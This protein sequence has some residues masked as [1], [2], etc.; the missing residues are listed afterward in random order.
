MSQRGDPCAL[1]LVCLTSARRVA[2][3]QAPGL[4]CATSRQFAPATTWHLRRRFNPSAAVPASVIALGS[5]ALVATYPRFSKCT[6]RRPRTHAALPHQAGIGRR[7]ERRARISAPNAP[8]TRTAPDRPRHAVSSLAT[9]PQLRSRYAETQA[10]ARVIAS[11][12]WQLSAKR[13]SVLHRKRD[14]N[15]RAD[16]NFMIALA[17]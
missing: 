1:T 12:S 8:V 7:D 11:M 16:P 4:A 6:A 2:W 5:V 15:H 13:S 10:A 3:R 9:R 17:R 14:I